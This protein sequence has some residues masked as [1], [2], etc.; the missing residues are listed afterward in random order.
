MR[1]RADPIERSLVISI[2]EEGNRISD[3]QAAYDFVCRNG[4][5]A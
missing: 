5:V 3:R 2:S 1:L 4:F